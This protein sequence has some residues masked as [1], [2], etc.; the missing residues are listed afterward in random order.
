MMMLEEET[1]Y[2]PFVEHQEGGDGTEGN[3]LNDKG[4]LYFTKYTYK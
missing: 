3:E 4:Y 2:N 1:G